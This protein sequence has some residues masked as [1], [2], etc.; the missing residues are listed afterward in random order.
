MRPGTSMNPPFSSDLGRRR[1]ELRHGRIRRHLEPVVPRAV[2]RLAL[3]VGS[4]I[5]V[6]SR[7]TYTLA[8]APSVVVKRSSMV[9]VNESRVNPRET[10]LK[11][12]RRESHPPLCTGVVNWRVNQVALPQVVL[13]LLRGR[14][15]HR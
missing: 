8:A 1:P 7:L 2:E 13:R 11:H 4:E 5:D 14:V 10:R 15:K 3:R 9:E 12:A 6:I